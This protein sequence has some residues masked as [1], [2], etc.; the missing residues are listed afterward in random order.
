MK[1]EMNEQNKNLNT[2]KNNAPFT[3]TVNGADISEFSFV[4]ESAFCDCG[5]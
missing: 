5:E 1:E 2:E 4:C 3:V